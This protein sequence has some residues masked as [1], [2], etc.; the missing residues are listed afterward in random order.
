MQNYIRGSAMTKRLKNTALAN[1]FNLRKGKSIVF[2]ACL[3]F[4]MKAYGNPAYK[5]Y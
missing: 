4:L 2:T 3:I 1:I 5:T